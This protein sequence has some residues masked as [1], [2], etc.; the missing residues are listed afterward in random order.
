MPDPIVKTKRKFK[1]KAD[2]NRQASLEGANTPFQIALRGAEVAGESTFDF[3]TGD[4]RGPRSFA[5]RTTGKQAATIPPVQPG[6]TNLLI[7]EPVLPPIGPITGVK[8]PKSPVDVTSKL[9]KVKAPKRKLT[10]V[11][12]IVNARKLQAI[13][14]TGERPGARRG[15]RTKGS[16][17]RRIN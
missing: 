6:K 9:P 8:I 17:G 15:N 10:S 7:N 4:G 13:S 14:P 1:N 16:K 3:D 11:K 5:A 12:G 2:R